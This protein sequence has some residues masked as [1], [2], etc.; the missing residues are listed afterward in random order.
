MASLGEIACDVIR[1][2]PCVV[3]AH[4][5][6]THRWPPLRLAR[7]VRRP[8]EDVG[9]PRHRSPQQLRL[10]PS[11]DLR[12]G[13]RARRSHRTV[14]AR[15]RSVRGDSD[16][17]FGSTVAFAI[18]GTIALAS[19]PSRTSPRDRARAEVDAYRAQLAQ[20]QAESAEAYR[21]SPAGQLAAARATRDKLGKHVTEHVVPLRKKYAGELEGYLTRLRVELP[22]AGAQ[23]HAALV[24]SG[25]K[26][27]ELRDV[28]VRAA[29]LERSIGWLARKSDEATRALRA[30]DH[31]SWMLEKLVELRDALATTTASRSPRSSHLPMQSSKRSSIRLPSWSSPSSRRSCF[32][33]S[34]RE[35]AMT[36]PALHPFLFEHPSGVTGDDVAGEL[37]LPRNEAVDLLA[38]EARSG[39]IDVSENDG[40]V[41]YRTTRRVPPRRNFVR[42]LEALRD[43][44]RRIALISA[45]VI[46]LFAFASLLYALSGAKPTPLPIAPRAARSE[47]EEAAAAARIGD[48]RSMWR[49]ELAELRRAD[50]VLASVEATCAA[51]WVG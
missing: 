29:V 17:I 49:E 31:K 37:A 35:P 11:L 42:S 26:H 2:T 40:T 50:A 33:V 22:K 24:E 25:D 15:R 7:R 20:Q 47:S 28:L 27:A 34:S 19:S 43:E 9:R 46:T 8:R 10:V 13:S 5:V 23:T 18:A 41:L 12:R 38:A 21:S 45:A 4:E 51:R 44:R 16:A 36:H 14:H 32:S 1:R 39:A 48:Q 30:L 3:T 6:Y